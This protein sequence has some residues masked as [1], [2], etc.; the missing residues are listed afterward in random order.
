MFLV[1]EKTFFKLCTVNPDSN[2]ASS[3]HIR[4]CIFFSTVVT[5]RHSVSL[6]SCI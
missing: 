6:F 3:V 1:V 4:S 5:V 2:H